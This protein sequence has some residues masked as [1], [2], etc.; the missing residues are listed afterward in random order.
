M[1]DSRH[2]QAIGGEHAFAKPHHQAGDDNA[3]RE[4]DNAGVVE[5]LAG[6]QPALGRHAFA[7]AQKVGVNMFEPGPVIAIIVERIPQ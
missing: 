5:F 3:G 7:M 4:N 6:V 2:G 1:D